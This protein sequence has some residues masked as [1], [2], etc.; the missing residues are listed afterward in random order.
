MSRKN[1]FLLCVTCLMFQMATVGA[2]IAAPQKSASGKAESAEWIG[3]F[4]G[5]TLDGWKGA[6]G[7]WTVADGAITG[8]TTS[9]TKLAAN[10]FLVWQG[11]KIGDFE[12]KLKFRIENGNSGIQFRSEDLGDFHVGGYQADIDSKKRYTGILYEERMRG[13]LCERGKKVEVGADNKVKEVGET[14]DGK[15]FSEKVDESQ[16]NQYTIVAKGNHITQT[17]NDFVTVDLID[18]GPKA[19]KEGILAFQIHVGPPMKVQFKDIQ[20]K[21]LSK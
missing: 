2:T 15:A 14:C 7:L 10:S 17:I 6:E 1:F 21:K 8:T 9:E 12:L 19:A 20:L 11:G 13:I 4:D 3:L 5:K 16:W 18:N